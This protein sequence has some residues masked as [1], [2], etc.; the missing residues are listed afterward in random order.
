M[1]GWKTW[2][3]GLGAIFAGLSMIAMAVGGT[4]DGSVNE[5]IEMV[6]AGLAV[7]GLGHKIEKAGK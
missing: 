6:V 1:S 5:G 7:L 4:G 2:A 3:A